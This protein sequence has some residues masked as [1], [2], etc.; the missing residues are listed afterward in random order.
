MRKADEEGSKK[1]KE[2]MEGDRDKEG[3]SGSETGV[4]TTLLLAG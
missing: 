3:E 2:R 4:P 1:R